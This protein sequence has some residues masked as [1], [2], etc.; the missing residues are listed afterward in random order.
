MITASTAGQ[1]V[2]D[3]LLML[4]AYESTSPLTDVDM[5]YGLRTL[6]RMIDSWSNYSLACYEVR[7]Q[8]AQLVPGQASYT[9]GPGGDFNMVRPLSILTDPGTAYVQDGNGN[10]YLMDVVPRDKWNLFANRSSIVTSN[11]PNV[12]FYDPQFP[13]G[14]INIIPYPTL[15]YT[16]FWDSMLQL[17][18]FSNSSQQLALPEGYELAM[19]SNLAVLL[20]PAF[21]DGPIDPIIPV[22]AS[23]SLG[24]IK[25]TNTRDLFAIYDQE[26][27]SRGDVSYNPYTDSVGA[28]NKVS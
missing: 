17:S 24:N 18:N 5:Q 7:E 14:I 10:N 23:T 9:I 19:V 15:A 12:M 1:I 4:G 8:S 25:R 28:V 6:N 20:K 26:I 13:L 27:V 21:L 11:F 22:M 3:A 2:T 16:M